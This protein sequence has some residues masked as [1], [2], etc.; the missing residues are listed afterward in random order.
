MN[1]LFLL[2]YCLLCTIGMQGNGLNK[3]IIT[4]KVVG[5]T[6]GDTFTALMNDSTFKIRLASIDS[7]EKKQAYGNV[8]KQFLASLIF[9]KTVQIQAGKLD[10]NKRQI[11]TVFYDGVN[12][13]EVMIKTGMAWHYVKY[14]KNPKLQL[15][16]NNAR[17]NRVG[18]WK[19]NNPVAPWLFR[20]P[21]NL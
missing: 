5:I 20:H 13:N 21:D 11:A 2:F 12:I 18:L 16:E 9:G 6:D 14:S 10:R 7:P 17:A 3:G 19:D 8:S 4:C 1:K 15:L